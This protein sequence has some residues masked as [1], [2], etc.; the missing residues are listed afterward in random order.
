[1]VISVRFA[2]SATLSWDAR[3]KTIAEK[4]EVGGVGFVLVLDLVRVDHRRATLRMIAS[5]EIGK[6]RPG[7][8]RLAREST[9][10]PMMGEARSEVRQALLDT[11]GERLRSC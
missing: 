6:R 5:D 9:G 4:A 7:R 10:D 2:L 3:E 8:P 11:T 1:M